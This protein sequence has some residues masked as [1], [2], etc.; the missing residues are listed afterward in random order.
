[1][2]KPPIKNIF[3]SAVSSEFSDQ[4]KEIARL[5]KL[6]GINSETQENFNQH[7]GLLLTTVENYIT[8]SDAVIFL[9][10]NIFGAKP[11]DTHFADFEHAINL[12]EYLNKI[13][14]PFFSYTQWE[15]LLAKKHNKPAF[16]FY[17][18][19]AI[20]ILPEIIDAIDVSVFQQ[21]YR[22]WL[23]KS[24]KH[25]YKF[26]GILD[27]AEKILTLPEL[28]NIQG[29]KPSNLPFSSLNDKFIGRSKEIE[30]IYIS[31]NKTEKSS[32]ITSIYST[33]LHGLGGIGKTRLAIEYA[34]RYKSEYSAIL[35]LLADDLDSLESKIAAFCKR[36]VLD[37]PEAE[38]PDVRVQYNAT[39]NW[40]RTNHNWLLIFDNVDT[41]KTALHIQ[42]MIP[43]LI[44][45]HIIITSRISTWGNSIEKLE[46]GLLSPEKALDL[47]EILTEN[48]RK[49]TDD[50]ETGAKIVKNIGYLALAIDQVSSYINRNA[51]S[52]KAYLTAW[53]KQHMQVLEWYDKNT[54]EYKKNMKE[55]YK[56]IAQ[57]WL[58]TF[59]VLSDGAQ[60]LLLR[61]AWFASD[62]IQESIFETPIPG[63]EFEDMLLFFTELE[64]YSML[65]RNNESGREEFTIHR[66]VQDVT[67][68]WQQK[69]TNTKQLTEALNWLNDAFVGS[70]QDVRNWP[71]LE[72]IAQHCMSVCSFA[73]QANILEPT[74]RL[75]NQIGILYLTKA[76][77]Q[78]AEPL[79]VRALAIDE[80]SFGEDHP[81]VG[82]IL[83]NLAQLLQATN[84]LAE[85]E[86][87]ILRAL[88][89][90]ERSY[91]K[92][93]PVVAID[94]NCLAL[95]LQDTDRLEEAESLL[96]RA[97]SIDEKSYG[98]DHPVV[99]LDL[100]NLAGLLR[101]TN[102]LEE[103]E[104]LMRRALS[105]EETNFGKDHPSVAMRQQNLAQ[106]LKD[107]DRLEEAEPLFRH[108]LSIAETSYGKDHPNVA[109]M[110]KNLAGLLKDTDRL[111]EAEPLM[112]RG[113]SI[114]E[115]SY[116]KNHPQIAAD[117][118][119][120]AH[121]LKDTDRL[122]EAESLMKQA[123]IIFIKSYGKDHPKS[124]KVMNNYKILLSESGKS[125]EEIEEIFDKI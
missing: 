102:R 123:L 82:A 118:Y 55:D 64:Q 73:E 31:L 92:E 67:R 10:G 2:S 50:D 98:K 99:A 69:D 52:Y 84:R 112:R 95:L 87:L 20:E 124:N 109:T 56:S 7:S 25:Y 116:D 9:V 79:M 47:L 101:V 19:D 11:S 65:K 44:D 23:S 81:A 37:L 53:D 6:K 59:N 8:R 30:Q 29:Y 21:N 35:F 76:D 89:I 57:T 28:T 24:G 106:L 63:V 38:N 49:F 70:A 45:G 33:V 34:I 85:A 113:L 58:T 5:L 97:L 125:A 68:Q 80:T 27:L 91:G 62:P 41:E 115:M 3:I 4:R 51:K 107:R 74:S 71:V 42:D 93:H 22:N 94:L 121:L 17:S 86:P 36:E 122:E 90:D 83:S 103:A 78:V 108:A 40:L 114:D 119:H 14:V 39:I 1:M 120:L 100:N 46:L 15:Y 77:Y 104:P 54:M 26:N 88:S 16:V 96:H 72:P 18:A 48:R 111:V 117:L 12:E 32:A 61:F 66:L 60:K 13:K 43:N 75:L 110:L 105:I